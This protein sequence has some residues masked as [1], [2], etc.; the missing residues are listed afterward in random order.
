MLRLLHLEVMN[1]HY[2]DGIKSEFKVNK[3]GCNWVTLGNSAVSF[4][5]QCK[6]HDINGN[7]SGD[8]STEQ[9][10]MASVL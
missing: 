9:N 2:S 4:I 7:G 5:T 8:I 3:A 1:I 10:Q 6:Q